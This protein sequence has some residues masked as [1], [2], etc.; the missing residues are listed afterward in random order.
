MVQLTPMRKGLLVQAVHLEGDPRRFWQ[1]MRELHW[2][3]V[4]KVVKQTGSPMGN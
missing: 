2:L 1:K 4:G 3:E